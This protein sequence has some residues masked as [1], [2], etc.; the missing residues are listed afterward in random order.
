M[1]KEGFSNPLRLTF[2]DP[3]LHKLTSICWDLENSYPNIA[4]MILISFILLNHCQVFRS[5][6]FESE[7][8]REYPHF[9]FKL[10]RVRW[11]PPDFVPSCLHYLYNRINGKAAWGGSGKIFARKWKGVEKNDN[12]YLSW[13]FAYKEGIIQEVFDVS[14][15]FEHMRGWISLRCRFFSFTRIYLWSSS[16]L[17][18]YCNQSCKST[19]FVDLLINLFVVQLSSTLRCDRQSHDVGFRSY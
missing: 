18:W 12:T 19:S 1:L 17:E 8:V 9:Q 13:Y 3:L 2:Y 4:L 10:P 11:N 16:G 5:C 15:G 14:S 6:G 7:L